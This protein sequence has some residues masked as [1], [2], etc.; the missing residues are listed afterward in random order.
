MP[1]E[2]HKI[3]TAYPVMAI[4][5]NIS[6]DSVTVT[7]GVTASTVVATT[8][9]TT[10]II[11]V[12]DTITTNGLEVAGDLT[13]A[14]IT[15][16][17]RTAA[18]ANWYSVTYGNGL[19]VAVGGYG[20][21]RVMTS[22][23]GITWTAR[24]AAEANWYSVTY[25][26]GL[27]V[28]V[29]ELDA[30]THGVMTSPDGITWTARTAAEA[31][32][33]NS[34]TYG[35]GLF[36]AV[37]DLDA[38]THGVMTS[39]DGITWTARTAAEANYW[40]SVTYG[41]GLF[42]AVGE[43]DAGTH[44]VMTSGKSLYNVIPTRNIYQGGMTVQGTLA[45]SGIVT[46]PS[47][48][49]TTI[50]GGVSTLTYGSTIACNMSLANTFTLTASGNAT[51]NAV[52]G[53]AGQNVDFII[54]NDGSAARTI[55]FGTGFKTNGTCIGAVG[56]VTHISFKYDGSSWWEIARW[57]ESRTRTFDLFIGTVTPWADGAANAGLM[58][59]D[60]DSV[61]HRNYLRWTSTTATQDYD[62]IFAWKIPDDFSTFPA[63]AM[64]IDVRTNDKTGN[65]CTL[66]MVGPLGVVD[67]GISG[68]STQGAL[69]NDVW[70][71]YTCTPSGTYAP[72]DWIH[73]HVHMGNDE[74]NNTVDI[75]RVFYKYIPR[76]G[77]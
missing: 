2:D 54:T 73:T 9:I 70:G 61:N 23:D 18:E 8:S 5:G 77:G 37:G 36:V 15:W 42:V 27:F 7:N 62:A 68:V 69:T 16:T 57:L 66:T 40:Y 55:T 67:T 28:A 47:G 44:G 50:V 11:D 43:L 30:G 39:P 12:T 38:G 51:I 52:G 34:V 33:W 56:K 46:S 59:I 1:Y 74:A 26:N 32:Y 35:N 17:A 64:S 19:F 53:T 10:P 48:V 14:G 65:V 49:F 72:D 20:T 24:T 71:T 13:N 21:S 45:A 3:I 75:A 76:I 29:G 22:P 63:G 4:S 58:T 41:N 6:A 31:N 60:H 25:G